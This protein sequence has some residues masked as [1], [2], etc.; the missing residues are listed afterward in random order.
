MDSLVYAKMKIDTVKIEGYL[1]R[2]LDGRHLFFVPDDYFKNATLEDYF[3]ARVIKVL[4]QERVI[5][6]VFYLINFRKNSI[7]APFPGRCALQFINDW[8]ESA[9]LTETFNYDKVY[10]YRKK[11]GLKY[12]FSV[13]YLRGD[14]IRI[15]IP[16]NFRGGY[17][18]KY[19]ELDKMK[20]VY[21]YF[22]LMDTDASFWP[23]YN[24][25]L[26][27]QFRRYLKYRKV[28]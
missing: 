25:W 24:T 5:D 10:H 3:N 16:E 11:R 9:V 13:Y 21:T 20:Q 27:D 1:F 17:G 6:S 4:G 12:M 26:R 14:F 2:P 7:S 22:V 8:A 23:L 28:R 15:I 18:E 19:V